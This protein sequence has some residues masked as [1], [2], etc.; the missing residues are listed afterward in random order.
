MPDTNDD[1]G[2]N[3]NQ[4]QAH[5]HQP[6]SNWSHFNPSNQ[7][8]NNATQPP[9]PKKGLLDDPIPSENTRQGAP[10]AAPTWF[11]NFPQ[12]SGNQHQQTHQQ[13]QVQNTDSQALLTTNSWN[14]IVQ[15]ETSEEVAKE[16]EQTIPTENNK[17]NDASTKEDELVWGK[18]I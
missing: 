14:T 3:Q 2:F 4:H 13:Q 9:A 18:S 8:N 11:Q 17:V 5:R 10:E 15:N 6:N 12:F 1:Y 16:T 7:Y